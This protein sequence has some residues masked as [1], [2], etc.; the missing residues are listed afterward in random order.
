MHLEAYRTN[1]VRSCVEYHPAVLAGIP[2]KVHPCTHFSLSRSLQ[3]G[4]LH[5]QSPLNMS[6]PRWF[7]STGPPCLIHFKTLPRT[8]NALPDLSPAYLTN[9]LQI[10]KLSCSLRSSSALPLAL[11]AVDLS[12]VGARTFTLPLHPYSPYPTMSKYWT[13]SQNSNLLLDSR[14]AFAEQCSIILLPSYW[15]F[16]Y[17]IMIFCYLCTYCGLL[18]VVVHCFI[19]E[20]IW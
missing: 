18:H 12:T 15:L 16:N 4:L 20:S 11:P 9:L 19:T 13:T 6:L 17:H 1:L 2:K 14:L 3:D 10:Y 5:P 8:C 7:S